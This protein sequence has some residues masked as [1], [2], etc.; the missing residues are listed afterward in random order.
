VT[1]DWNSGLYGGAF[2]G[3]WQFVRSA[4]EADWFLPVGNPEEDVRPGFHLGA[5]LGLADAYGD[6]SDVPYTERF[7]SGGSRKLRGFRYRGVGPNIGGRPIGGD[8]SVGGT[9]EYRIP[10]YSVLQPGILDPDPWAVDPSELRASVGVG[11]GLT[12]PIPLIFNFGF[13]IESGK[14][15]REQVFSFSLLNL[16]F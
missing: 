8:T 5:E 1:V 11:F 14:G 15:D 4:V 7:F 2:G 13:P 10:L 3:D 9:I 12:H 16:S 6:S